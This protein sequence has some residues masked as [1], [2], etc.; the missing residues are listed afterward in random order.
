MIT[1]DINR[2]ELNG[3][4]NQSVFVFRQTSPQ[5]DIPVTDESHI[6][7]Y[8]DEVL[9][10][11][12]T[13]YTV[14]IL[15]KLATVTFTV[16]N[17]PGTGT[18]NV[19]FIREVPF[20]QETDLANN[21]QLEA[22][23]LESQL[24]LIVNQAQQLNDKTSRDFRLSDTLIGTDATEAQTTLNK[25]VTERANK[26]LKFD[27]SGN[28]DIS[29]VNIDDA[30]TYASN[31]NQ[32][33]LDAVAQVALAN[34]ARV[35]AEAAESGADT[36]LDTFDDRFLGVKG[37]DPTV[38]NDG[39][40]LVDGAI[41]Y[42][43]VSDVIK[44][45]D[46]ST[47]PTWR[48][49]TTTVANQ[50]NIDALVL[51]TDGTSST[52]GTNTNI[53]QVNTV[54]LKINDVSNY[55]DVYQISDFTENSGA[56]PNT[57]GGGN[58]LSKGDMAFDTTLDA[59][60]VWNGATWS[61]GVNTTDGVIVKH[62]Y[63][64]NG[65][66]TH[67]ALAHDQ[68]MEIVYLNGVK[69]KAG[70]GSSNNDYFSVSGSSTTTYVGD[71]NAATHIKFHSPPAFT[72]LVS[73]H[74][75]GASAN[76]LAVPKTGGTYTGAV[77]FSAG[78]TTNTAT[79]NGGT[80]SNITAINGAN[81]KIDTTAKHTGIGYDA[82]SNITSGI[83]NTGL[84]HL[85]LTATTTG[86]M[87]TGVGYAS[88]NNNLDGAKNSGFGNVSLIGNTSGSA[89]CAFGYASLPANTSGNVNVSVGTES[90]MTAT[91][92]SQNVAVGW[93]AGKL[94]NVGS[95][96]QT[97]SSNTCIGT[98]AMANN[99]DGYENTAVGWASLQAAGSAAKNVAL[100]VGASYSCTGNINT[101][102]GYYA[103]F[104]ITTGN[105]IIAL[106]GYAGTSVSPGGTMTTQTNQVII[107]DNWT[108]N[109]YCSA[110]WATSSDERDKADIVPMAHG[111]DVIES[112]NPINYFWDKRS[113]Y[114]D[115]TDMDNIIK[116]AGDGSKK[117]GDNLRTGFSAQNVKSALDSVGYTGH[118]VIN[119][120]DPENLTI[121]ET[122]IIPFLVNAI[123]ELSAKVTALENS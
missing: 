39:A 94:L 121:I 65:S 29:T 31:A 71:G 12:T 114:W 10:S 6:K 17:V 1:T 104:N 113:S 100:G 105:G 92:C 90:L 38:D 81:F 60:R 57:D 98:Q 32:S 86:F 83:E 115:I 62:E 55:A 46:S 23:S 61:S 101:T 91:T 9:K 42:S 70:D 74:A 22:E 27:A 110:T 3:G 13:H 18:G 19:I 112:I 30:S 97:G 69:L 43:S 82:G 89:N 52:G 37:S 96:V 88:L 120:T 122:N 108:T 24:D 15:N 64:A 111:L 2:A 51:G 79:I 118:S 99:T 11:I 58:A 95:G 77:S 56:G 7:V 63:V 117:V 35:A 116:H 72:H 40:T 59:L 93:S 78:L 75:W 36:L 106:G 102:V 48:Q 49:I 53:A 54:A 76:T 45:Y 8:V 16:G 47:T 34:T 80:L 119:S 5:V 50:T 85:A 67:F 25:T 68:G 103:G 73:L 109:A 87:N 21:S 66:D 44:V 33:Y 14:S 41:Y 28:I 26:S 123:K 84:G 107:G 20:K 4:N